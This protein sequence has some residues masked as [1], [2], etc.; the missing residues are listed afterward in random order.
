MLKKVLLLLDP[1]MPGHKAR[2]FAFT[3]VK[4]KSAHLT[5]LGVLDTPWITAAQ[6]EPLGGSI[7]K[8]QRDE[9]IIKSSHDSISLI[10]Q[11]FCH[12]AEKEGIVYK[13]IEGEGFP[14]MVIECLAHEHDVIVIGQTTD[15]HFDL[16]EDSSVIVHHVARD[17]PRPL[18][19]VPKEY[20]PHGSSIL[21]AQ[22]GSNQASR[23]LHMLLLLGLA[24]AK[25]LEIV[26]IHTDL[27]SAERIAGRSV[28]M[29][30]AHGVKAKAFTSV[31]EKDV[32]EILLERA[33]T[34]EASLICMGG[35]SHSALRDVL[36]GSTAQEVLKQVTVPVFIHH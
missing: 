23:A 7:F 13:A 25:E 10:M 3:L 29:C 8:I 27:E 33:K 17:N 21:V 18:F 6:P 34:I 35:F 26:C 5:A 28:R 4:E 12:D 31:D 30:E 14:S 11:E 2:D 24:D 1:S 9:E 19:I 22:D 20:A 36:F 16:D 15:I 32:S